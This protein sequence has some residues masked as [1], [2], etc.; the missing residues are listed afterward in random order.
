MPLSARWQ[1]IGLQALG[2]LMLSAG[3]V[4]W[5][6]RCFQL[7]CRGPGNS[8]E[9]WAALA[10]ARSR[11][12]HGWAALRWQRRAVALAPQRA[13]YHYNL[14]Y[15]AEQLHD[16]A[17]AEV[18]FRRA[19]DLAPSMDLAW[20]GLGRI[21][22]Q[23]GRWAE[24]QAAFEANARLQPLSPHGWEAI[25]RLQV[26]QGLFESAQDTVA[27]LRTFEPKVAARL[28]RELFP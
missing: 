18:S 19:L 15:L 2:P 9:A 26:T 20:Y 16:V 1:Q 4:L 27:H 3:L 7:A 17:L 12:G 5:A 11:R 6:R 22:R 10:Y 24:A 23:T 21:L 25:A 13:A 8:P 14:G 28:G